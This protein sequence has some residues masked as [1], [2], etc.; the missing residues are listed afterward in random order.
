MVIYAWIV[1]FALSSVANA[2]FCTFTGCADGTKCGCVPFFQF[3]DV[4][5]NKEGLC[6]MTESGLWLSLSLGLLT[7]ILLIFAI[8]CC[9]CCWCCKRKGTTNVVHKWEGGAD[10]GHIK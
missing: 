5:T 3:C 8:L 10:Y 9:C 6:T 1:L 4:A 2:S 7:L